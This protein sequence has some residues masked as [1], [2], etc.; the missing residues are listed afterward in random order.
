[1]SAFLSWIANKLSRGASQHYLTQ[2]VQLRHRDLA[3][4]GAA[5]RAY[6]D[7]GAAGFAHLRHGQGICELLPQEHASEEA[8]PDKSGLKRQTP[9]DRNRDAAGLDVRLGVV[10]GGFEVE[11]D[12]LV[13]LAVKA[14]FLP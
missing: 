13:A 1:M 7:R 9:V 5:C 10:V 8:D 4:P 14:N 12:R 6:L 2:R 11:G 3:L